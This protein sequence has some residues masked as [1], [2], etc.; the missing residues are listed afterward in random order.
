MALMVRI[1]SESLLP[2]KGLIDA[3]ALPVCKK[4]EAALDLPEVE[5][6]VR[7]NPEGVIPEIGVGGYSPDAEKLFIWLDPNYANFE[8]AIRQNL[9]GTLAHEAHHTARWGS[10]G[11]GETLLEGVISEGLADHFDMEITG[12]G[13]PPWA[14][15]VSGNDLEVLLERAQKEFDSKEYD[16]KAWM[17]GSEEKNIPRWT[18]YS[19]GFELVKRYMAKSGKKASEL[20]DT[21]AKEFI[22]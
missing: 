9:P 12:G 20:V 2:S 18:G 16:E 6:I 4:I 21:E 3:V 19:I 5:V 14:R 15:E 11:Y 1:D 17:F 7:D 13:V 10:V 22:A 8:N